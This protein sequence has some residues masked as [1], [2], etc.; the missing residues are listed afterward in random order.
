MMDCVVPAEPITCA[1]KQ[2]ECI[3]N[4]N[5]D[6]LV[7]LLSLFHNTAS[8]KGKS[9]S[10]VNALR[11][12]IKEVLERKVK[13]DHE[14]TADRALNNVAQLRESMDFTIGSQTNESESLEDSRIICDGNVRVLISEQ[15]VDLEGKLEYS[16]KEK[17]KNEENSTI[18]KKGK[19]I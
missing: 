15:M 13:S 6:R 7:E 2:E 8:V 1:R 17:G 4:G 14:K 11:D 5:N 16:E 3:N 18:T 12:E 19:L 9:K 10:N